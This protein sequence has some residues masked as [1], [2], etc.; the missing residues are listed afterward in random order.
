MDQRQLNRKLSLVVWELTWQI[1][2]ATQEEK[3][4]LGSVS[5]R[6]ST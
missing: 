6:Y 4:Q 3:S 2:S 5:V 1:R